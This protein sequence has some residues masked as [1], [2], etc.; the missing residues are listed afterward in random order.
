MQQLVSRVISLTSSPSSSSS[1][2]TR[3]AYPTSDDDRVVDDPS[4]TSYLRFEFTDRSV[5][6]L[7]SAT[8]RTETLKVLKGQ[9]ITDAMSQGLRRAAAAE[10]L[11]GA[12]AWPDEEG[13]EGKAARAEARQARQQKRRL[14]VRR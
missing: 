8:V 5:V 4:D 11:Q 12:G 14:T 2:R 1:S 9:S 3:T 7:N 13:E 6:V 10:G